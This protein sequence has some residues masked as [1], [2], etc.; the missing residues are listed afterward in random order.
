MNTIQKIKNVLELQDNFNKVVNP[1]WQKA[2]YKFYRAV[3]LEMAEFVDGIG[4]W[5]WWKAANRGDREQCV[6]E[7]VDI[8]H[9]VLSDAIINY[10]SAELIE[11]AYS[12]ALAR[13]NKN[14]KNADEYVYEEVEAFLEI[15]LNDV[16][17][18]RGI[19]LINFFD[20]VVAFDVTLDE[21][22]DKYVGKNVLNKFRQDNGYKAGTYVK[23][24]DDAGNEDNVYLV[25]YRDELGSA[26]TFDGLYDKLR[27]KYQEVLH[28]NEKG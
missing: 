5:K 8:F 26:L 19:P 4:T 9:F 7:L 23:T 14:P 28:A 3:W 10:R 1:D 18:S 6:L 17:Q 25:K 12:R 27:T 21:L 15:M 22:L 24:W 11:G 20:V 16:R 2:G 13:R